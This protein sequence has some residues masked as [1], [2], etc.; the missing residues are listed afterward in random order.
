ASHH[1]PRRLG[2]PLF[3]LR[4]PGPRPGRLGHGHHHRPDHHRGRPGRG[5]HGPG[6]FHGNAGHAHGPHR[7]ARPVHHPVPRRRRPVPHD[8]PRRGHEPAH[9]DPPAPRRRGPP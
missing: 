5:G 1:H 6:L 4:C 7:R 8:G 3:G 9:R 2:I